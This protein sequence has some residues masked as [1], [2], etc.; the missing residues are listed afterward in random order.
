MSNNTEALQKKIECSCG[1]EMDEVIFGSLPA[2]EGHYWGS[3]IRLDCPVCKKCKVVYFWPG[4]TANYEVFDGLHIPTKINQRVNAAVID[5]CNIVWGY[6][7]DPSR[8]IDIAR[9]EKVLESLVPDDFLLLYAELDLLTGED[10]FHSLGKIYFAEDP[11]DPLAEIMST[12]ENERL[13]LE[14]SGGHMSESMTDWYDNEVR[15]AARSQG[16]TTRAKVRVIDTVLELIKKVEEKK[17][18]S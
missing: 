9:V 5:V 7:G 13:L 10:H 4:S 12:A 3:K 16:Q 15:A 18:S 8:A 2:P 14:A 11:R 17:K 6:E 1:N